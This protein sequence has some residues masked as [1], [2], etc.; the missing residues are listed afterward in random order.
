[1]PLVCACAASTLLAPAAQASTPDWRTYVHGPTT[2][3]VQPV[4]ATAL[5]GHVRHASGLAGRGTKATTLTVTPGGAPATVLLDYGKEVLGRPYLDIKPSGTATTPAVQLT[6]SETRQYLFSPGSS[7]LAT[8]A[9]AAGTTI[10]VAGA[11]TFA[12]GDT[13][14]IGSLANRI[15]A[16]SGTTLTLAHPLGSTASQGTAVTSTPGRLTGDGVGTGGYP[17][18]QA[19]TPAA[20]SHVSGTFEGGLRYETITL[21]TPGTVVLRAAGIDFQAYGAIRA[22]IRAT[23]NPAPTR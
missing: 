18:Q 21:S 2:S 15:V 23:S 10:T 17:R 22:S 14:R 12:V 20:Q 19:I 5:S 6:F 9:A 16:V 11:S 4:G 8:A 7:T 3:N 1:M 13:V